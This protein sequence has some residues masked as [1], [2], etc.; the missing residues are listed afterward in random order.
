MREPRV[1]FITGEYPPLY[2]GVG[3]Y[4][5]LLRLALA[6]LGDQS[7]VL[8]SAGAG[9]DGVRT[10][11]SWNWRIAGR[12][13]RLARRTNS[14]IVHIQ[15]QA[16]AFGMSPAINVLPALLRRR[17]KVPVVT[18]FH[19]LRPPY[20]FPKAGRLRRFV[21][22]RMARL[23]TA[24][25][26]TNPGDERILTRNGVVPR[27]IPIGVNL[28]PPSSADREIR[29]DTVAF[30]GFPSRTKGIDDLIRAIGLIDSLRRPLLLL[31]GAQGEPSANN[32]II[33]AE[34]IDAMAEEYEVRLE[35]T[36]YLPPQDASNVLATSG[37]IALPFVG[38]ASLRNGSLLSGPASGR[39]VITPLPPT[40]GALLDIQ[41][42]PQLILVERGGVG[43]L[44]DAIERA[45]SETRGAHPL[46]PAFGWSAIGREHD[47]LYRSLPGPPA[48]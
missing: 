45:L 6:G 37:A 7:V 38:G 16:G 18:T 29:R 48:W 28:P 32:D 27:R 9:G 41:G 10:V 40:P 14:N 44:W 24:V 21:M 43:E 25:I 39:P 15:Y 31:V 22:L 47:R 30:H 4:T 42:L 20:L 2:G 23:S 34:A 8:A 3:D 12:V 11:S 36:G 26:V 19:D 17:L 5:H 33:S 13:D 46:P 1:L 35:R